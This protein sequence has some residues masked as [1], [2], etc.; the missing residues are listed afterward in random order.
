MA[1]ARIITRSQACSRELALDL[2]ARGYAVEIVSPDAI[3]DNIADLELRVEAG[4]GDQLVASVETHDG[5]RSASLE[6]L[7]YLKAPM[8]D[9]I[10]RPPE[11]LELAQAVCFPEQLVS[12]HAEPSVEDVEIPVEATRLAPTA[13]APAAEIPLD[14]DTEEGAHLIPSPEQLASPPEVP[15]YFAVEESTFAQPAK[16]QHTFAFPKKIR[17][18]LAPQWRNLSAGWGWRAVFT[19]AGVL[20]LAI[21]LAFG[22]RRTGNPA[23]QSSGEVPVEKVAAASTDVNLLSAADS[24]R[25]PGKAAPQ[26]SALATPSATYPDKHSDHKPKE[27]SF[28]KTGPSTAQASNDGPRARI[29]RRHG[30]DLVARDTVTYLDNRFE[31]RASVRRAPKGEPATLLA[32]R[33]PRSRRRDGGVIA[34]NSVTYLNDKPNPKAA[35]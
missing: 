19:F 24:E 33:H 9:F 3:P 11:P 34:A 7:H 14:P 29:S 20:T 27:S 5:G 16:T 15:T 35:K 23:A 10:R 22:M 2:L 8:G 30:D 17:I 32:R 25:D 21:V 4:P 13:I 31:Q 28:A 12:V 26:I 18:R 1:L 6:F